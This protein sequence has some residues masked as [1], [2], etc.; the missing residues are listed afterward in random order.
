MVGMMTIWI[1]LL[2]TLQLGSN[3]LWKLWK[4]LVP[5]LPLTN[6]SRKRIPISANRYIHPSNITK[7]LR[8][9]NLS[10]SLETSIQILLKRRRNNKLVGILLELLIRGNRRNNS[11]RSRQL[12]QLVDIE[13]NLEIGSNSTIDSVLCKSV[14]R[15]A[16]NS[17]L[18]F[19][20]TYVSFLTS[21]PDHKRLPHF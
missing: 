5:I 18:P 14:C 16:K 3:T 9:R 11:S 12:E 7:R 8:R 17:L 2:I 4:I 20:R 10:T 19:L 21:K 15:L 6:I 1:P 13:S